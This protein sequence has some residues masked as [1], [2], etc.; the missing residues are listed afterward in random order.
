MLVT[1][2]GGSEHFNRAV[3]GS[4]IILAQPYSW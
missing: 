2:P 3:V 1:R 4:V